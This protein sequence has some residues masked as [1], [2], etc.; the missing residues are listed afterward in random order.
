MKKFL[1][2]INSSSSLEEND[3]LYSQSFLGK[4]ITK[5]VDPLNQRK[6]KTFR[7]FYPDS[8]N[9]EK[10][11]LEKFIETSKE[12]NSLVEKM[13]HLDLRKIKLS[14]PVNFLIRMNLGDPLIFIPKHDERHLNQ[15]ESVKN[16]GEFPHQQL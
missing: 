14:S 11:I 7:P 12:L 1:N 10:N 3:F 9:I 2:I 13:K 5:G 16:H 4:F 6:T 8:S 15:A